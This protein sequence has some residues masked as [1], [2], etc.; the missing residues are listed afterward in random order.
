MTFA[1]SLQLS[2]DSCTAERDS[3]QRKTGLQGQLLQGLIVPSPKQGLRS[4]LSLA[5]GHKFSLSEEFWDPGRFL[6]P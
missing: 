6:V 4:F 5:T 1:S 3:A 2:V